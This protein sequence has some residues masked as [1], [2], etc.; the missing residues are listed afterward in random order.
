MI[1]AYIDPDP[2][3]VILLGIHQWWFLKEKKPMKPERKNPQHDQLASGNLN[4]AIEHGNMASWS[5]QNGD[6]P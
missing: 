2:S 3:W 1:M 5:T 4:I 6:S